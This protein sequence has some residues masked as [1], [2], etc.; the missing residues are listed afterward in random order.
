MHWALFSALGVCHQ[1]IGGRGIQ[2]VGDIMSALEDIM[3][4]LR[5]VSVHWG[6]IISALADIIS[7]LG[8]GG[9]QCIGISLNVSMISPN[10]LHIHYTW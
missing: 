9:V 8:G 5:I 7:A 10:P 6:C 3:S 2:C 4:P 1:C